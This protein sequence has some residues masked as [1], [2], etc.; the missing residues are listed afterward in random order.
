MMMIPL[1]MRGVCE[2][3]YDRACSIAAKPTL[4]LGSL[5][6]FRPLRR[7]Y[8]KCKIKNADQRAP[9]LLAQ[10]LRTSYGLWA[11]SGADGV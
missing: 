8:R 4:S 11:E 1:E 3:A 9:A 6:S 7:N 2:C 5:A 10:V